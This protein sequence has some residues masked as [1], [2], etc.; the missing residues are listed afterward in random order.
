MRMVYT[1]ATIIDL[2]EVRAAVAT[3]NG[4]VRFHMRNGDTVDS[5]NESLRSVWDADAAST[6][7]AL[8][9]DGGS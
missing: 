8:P 4:G 6:T 7:P 5:P 3:K 1:G 2:D 9:K